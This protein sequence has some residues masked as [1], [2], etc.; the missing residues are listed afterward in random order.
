MELLKSSLKTFLNAMTYPDR[1]VYPVASTNLADFYN[2]TDVYL[3]A[4]LRPKLHPLVFQQEGWSLQVADDGA[5]SYKGVV[6]NEMKGVYSSP[7]MVN[8]MAVQHSLFPDNVYGLSSGG[9]PGAIPDLTYDAFKAFHRQY[10]HPSNALLFFYGDDPEDKRLDIA[11]AHL[12]AFARNSDA[13][14]TAIGLQPALPAPRE[15]TVPYPA[16]SDGDGGG[17]GG[18]GDGGADKH[19]ATV[20]W[21]LHHDGAEPLDSVT[22]LGLSVLDHL[23]LGTPSSTLRKA[24]TDSNLGESV[25]GSGFGDDLAQPTYD[26]GLSGIQDAAHVPAVQELV[27]STLESVAAPG[28]G[29]SGDHIS[30]SL[31]TLEFRLREFATD[32]D[33]PKGV[34]LFL[35]AAS[36]FNYRRNELKDMQYEETLTQ[37]KQ[38][39]RD[40]PRYFQD[41]IHKYLLNNSHRVFVHTYPDHGMASDRAA[42]E[43]QRLDGIKT[44]A[45]ADDLV[46]YKRDADALLE[47]QAAVDP[48]ELL[49]LV[50]SLSVSD[51]NPAIRHIPQARA[52][53][54]TPAGHAVTT[55]H[56]EQASQGIGYVKLAFDTAAVPNHLVPLLPLFSRCLTG[57]GTS[58]TDEV[59]MGYRVGTHTGGLSASPSVLDVRAPG[60]ASVVAFLCLRFAC[61]SVD[62]LTP[63][64]PVFR[65]V[66]GSPQQVLS[67]LKVSAK[68]LQDRPAA[69]FDI[70]AEF[71]NCPAFNNPDRVA[72][73][74]RD[75]ISAHESGVLMSGHQY[76]AVYLN[77]GLSAPGWMSEQMGGVAQLKVRPGRRWP[78]FL[79]WKEGSP[80]PVCL[81]ACASVRVRTCFAVPPV[82]VEARGNGLARRAQRLDD[83][84]AH[85]GDV[86]QLLGVTHRRQRH[87]DCIRQR[88]DVV[89]EVAAV[90][91]PR[92]R[93]GCPARVFAVARRHG[94]GGAH[95]SELRRQGRPRVR[96]RGRAGQCGRRQQLFVHV[97]VV[98][99]SA[100][101]GRRVRRHVQLEPAS[102]DV[103]VHVV[104]RPEPSSH[105]A[106]VRRH[107]GVPAEGRPRHGRRRAQSR[108]QHRGQ[109]G[110]AAVAG[111]GGQLGHDQ[112]PAGH[113]RGRRAAAPG[114]NAGHVDQRLFGACRPAG[115]RARQRG[116]RGGGQPRRGGRSDRGTDV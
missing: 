90:R 85:G 115:R 17:G 19:F 22:R 5:L 23:L 110:R 45:T 11:E 21:V 60:S 54:V 114:P 46:Q 35:G 34:M 98:G 48:P 83:A 4:V 30:A 77:S 61:L 37:L 93:L 13:E 91:Q 53:V 112:V 38:R 86:R 73:F 107:G 27:L 18:G 84:A 95:A 40:D 102:Q 82:V 103:Q 65:Q 14:A 72:A 109:H 76:A 33:F 64:S 88:V 43:Q 104:P 20:G 94:A 32:S 52:E 31:S 36:A 50:P 79:R 69:L 80:S 75:D 29:F 55:L 62:T 57:L 71:I 58:E 12:S 96:R 56:H 105:A 97:M 63:C 108:P 101:A 106:S 87:I 28:A 113:H 26:V 68:A 15:V 2:L 51:L 7:D 100:G 111:V 99:A 81:C 42:A 10:Y 89:L 39:I 92:A 44:A 1:T 66:P 49:A 8:Y 47:R 16:T 25:S 3:D 78:H 116:C 59:A 6:F 9:D 41:L 74:I 70:L 67:H 24:L